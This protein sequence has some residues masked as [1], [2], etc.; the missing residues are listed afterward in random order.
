[1]STNARS[2]FGS[3]TCLKF[4]RP[5]VGCYGMVLTSAAIFRRISSLIRINGGPELVEELMVRVVCHQRA[6]PNSVSIFL[7]RGFI[8][9]N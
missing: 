7:R 8:H 3:F 9:L 1:M 4:E 2:A 5:H 6:P